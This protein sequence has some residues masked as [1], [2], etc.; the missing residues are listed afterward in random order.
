MISWTTK[1]PSPMKEDH[2]TMEKPAFLTADQFIAI[3]AISNIG[4]I[5][6][7]HATAA[8]LS[9]SS[10]QVKPTCPERRRKPHPIQDSRSRVKKK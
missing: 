6:P 8:D 7:M 2:V 5:F 4:C 1:L 3:T 9:S 10:S